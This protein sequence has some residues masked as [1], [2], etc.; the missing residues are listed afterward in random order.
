MKKRKIIFVGF[1]FKHHLNTRGGYHHIK[2][3]V[4][5]DHIINGQKE[6]NF[7]YHAINILPKKLV[8]YYRKYFGY[9]LWL[10]ELRCIFRAFFFQ[11]QVF[12]I[13][14]AENILKHLGK[15]KGDTNQVICTVHQPFATFLE[16]K[17]WMESL[18]TV[19]KIILVSSNELEIFKKHFDVPVKYIPHGVDT[20]FFFPINMEKEHR[21]LMVGNWLRDFNFA[22]EVFKELLSLDEKLKMTVVSNPENIHFFEEN[23]RLSFENNI[24]D[25]RLRHLYQTSKLLFLPLKE[26]TANN[27][28]LEAAAC[29]TTILI[30]THKTTNSYFNRELISFVNLDKETTVTKIIQLLNENKVSSIRNYVVNHY[31]WEKI[32]LETH[33][34]LLQ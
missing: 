4:D 31:A 1:A 25:D 2:E 34:Y 29:G 6:Y 7:V 32:A 18:K 3:Y 13:I 16:N 28:I 9:R 22:N 21:I 19:D 5:Y 11:N 23:D 20:R 27:A 8:R 14:Y 30:A 17:S 33:E 15:F 26:F 24:S 10:T 12:H